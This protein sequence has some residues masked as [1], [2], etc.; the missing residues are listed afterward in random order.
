[1]DLRDN[2]MGLGYMGLGDLFCL[3]PR[4]SMMSQLQFGHRINRIIAAGSGGHST[5]HCLVLVHL[6]IK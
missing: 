3:I 1:M 5:R 4:L 6:T 2:V